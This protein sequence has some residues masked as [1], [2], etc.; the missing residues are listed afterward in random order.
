MIA[1][2]T[3]SRMEAREV[4]AR[5]SRSLTHSQCNNGAWKIDLKVGKRLRLTRTAGFF[6][7]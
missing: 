2:V 7:L 6:Y 3:Q 4:L 5:A 1:K